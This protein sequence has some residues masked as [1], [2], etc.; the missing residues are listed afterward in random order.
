[1]KVTILD[2]GSGEEEEIIIKC[3][4]LTEDM[5][6]LIN[7]FR[8]GAQSLRPIRGTGCFFWSQRTCSILNR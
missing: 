1:M 5:V 6:K 7:Q 8:R 2:I 3:S 4:V